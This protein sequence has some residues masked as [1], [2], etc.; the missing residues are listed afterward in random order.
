[1]NQ[2]CDDC[3]IAKQRRLPFPVQVA[4]RVT[5]QLDLW[6]GDLCGPI[7][8]ATH[9][10]K[11]YFLLLVDDYSRYM[12]IGL[13]RSKDEALEAIKKVQ[14]IAEVEKKLKLKALRS[15]RGGEF[16]SAKFVDH[17]E[18][19]RIKHFRTSPYTPQHNGIVE[20][21]NQTIVGMARSLLKSMGVPAK[22]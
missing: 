18:R 2:V 17:Y 12:W 1:M 11:R 5:Q 13:L 14:T 20:R 4:Y 3:M 22:F 10:G 8:P 6:H 19:H 15:D 16:T 7:S 21:R 9:S